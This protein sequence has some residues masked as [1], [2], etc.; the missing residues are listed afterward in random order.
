MLTL[1]LTICGLLAVVT[2]RLPAAVMGGKKYRVT[3]AGA[4]LVGTILMLAYP[5]FWLLGLLLARLPA[6]QAR[7][8]ALLCHLLIVLG[9]LVAALIAGRLVRTPMVA[10]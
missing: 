1:I 5:L 10:A 2:G 6:E 9:V 3:G 8:Y 7:D 4:R